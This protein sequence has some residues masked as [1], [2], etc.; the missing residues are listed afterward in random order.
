MHMKVFFS[1]LVIVLCLIA[2]GCVEK[3]TPDLHTTRYYLVVNGLITDQPEICKVKLFW[4][5]T[6]GEIESVPV[7]GCDVA[8]YDDLGHVFQ[9]AESEEPGT[10]CSDTATF[11]GIVGRTYTLHIETNNAAS[12]HYTY[13]SEPVEMRAVPG[14]DSIYFEKETIRAATQYSGAQEGCRIYLDTH[15][16][17]GTC[18]YYRWD[19]TE[20]WKILVPW[21]SVVNK[22][23][24]VAENSQAI[25]IKSTSVLSQ[26]RI[27][28]QPVTFITN[29][30]DRLA[31]RYSIL[32]NQYSLSDR[33]FE[34]WDKL[35]NV[36]QNTGGLYGTIPYS[37]PSN[38]IC[39]EEPSEQVLGYFSVSAKT[40][41]RIYVQE[42][43]KGLVNLYRNCPADTFYLPDASMIP[44][45]N[46]TR[47]ILYE[48]H[49]SCGNV[50]ITTNEHSCADCTVRGTLV[51]PDFWYDPEE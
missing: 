4:S 46:T 39:L 3:F 36:T 22:R 7:S 35:R 32:V 24:W 18:R 50:E 33:E 5:I 42:T 25:N 1:S 16:P 45:I 13:E 51:K 9:F 2:A 21:V 15:D 40:S 34:F 28:R 44:N 17:A 26:D 23:C 20:T 49:G 43:F 31:E 29:Q 37:T 47:W 6:P 30:T 14:I 8:V 27:T 19:F 10:Y 12:N 41:K 11:R 48:C 38:M